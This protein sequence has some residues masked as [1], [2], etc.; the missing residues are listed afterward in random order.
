MLD[1]WKKSAICIEIG[2]KN[3]QT[4]ETRLVVREISGYANGLEELAISEIPLQV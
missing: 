3:K 4:I 2:K 1:T